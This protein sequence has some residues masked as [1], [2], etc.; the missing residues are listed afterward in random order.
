MNEKKSESFVCTDC[1]LALISSD[2]VYTYE[3]CIECIRAERDILRAKL[4]AA[5]GVLE[6]T[7]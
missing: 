7:K 6:V 4:D 5:H 1:C 3:D 2:S